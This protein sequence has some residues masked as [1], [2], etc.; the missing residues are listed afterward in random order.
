MKDLTAVRLRAVSKVYAGSAPIRALENVSLDITAG[1]L[2]LFEGPSGSGKTTLLSLIGGLDRPTNGHVTV[3]GAEL[4]N[5]PERELVKYRQ[6]QLGFVFQDFKL[7]DV[8]TALENVALALRLRGMRRRAAL[9]RARLVLEVLGVGSRCDSRPRDLSGGEQQRVAVA[10][11]L[12]PQPRLILADEPTAN[13]DSMTGTDVMEA[14]KGVTHHRSTTVI[15]VSHD[16]RIAPHADRVF[17]LLDG[18]LVENL[19]REAA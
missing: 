3:F 8:L 12:A 6:T 16:A 9:A 4:G 5:L 15:V 7:I 14:L 11:A 18:R 1:T 13:L 17:R 2:S 10:R 19:T